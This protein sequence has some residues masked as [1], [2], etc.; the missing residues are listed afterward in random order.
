MGIRNKK[1]ELFP[2]AERPLL[3]GHRGCSNAAPENTMA[4]FQ[5]ILDYGVPGVELDVHLCRTGELVV[6]H[7]FN[8]QR[9]TGLDT[10]IEDTDYAAIAELDAGVWFSEEFRGEKVPLLDDVMDLLG[11]K[12]Y[13]D[14]EI[15]T[16]CRKCGPIESALAETVSKRGFN[17]R[18]M[19]SSFNPFSMR[20]MR[21]ID[22]TIPTA[23]IYTIHE[24]VPWYLRRG[25]GRFLSRPTALKPNRHQ[26]TRGKMLF[27]KEIAGYPI[28][29]W[30]ENDPEKA[31]EYLELGVDG[32]VT[33]VPEWML[34]LCR[35]YRALR[36]RPTDTP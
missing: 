13:Y 11:E 25:E 9:I 10:A 31:R 5:K 1:K 23:L 8:L 30:T 29:T 34:E 3:F 18:V 15:K 32:I 14:I 16:K 33:N 26:I 36:N 21:K 20:E 27:K 4:A 7:D 19:I 2:F 28:I 35:E 22:K 12:V 6:T 24:H 17:N